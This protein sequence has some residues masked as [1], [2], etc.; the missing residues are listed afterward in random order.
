MPSFGTPGGRRGK[1]FKIFERKLGQGSNKTDF[2]EESHPQGELPGLV[3]VPTNFN[4][5]L[6]KVHSR[7]AYQDSQPIGEGSTDSSQAGG[8]TQENPDPGL[9]GG[10]NS[11]IDRPMGEEETW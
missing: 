10:G 7:L 8:Q 11:L 4:P 3:F 5:I 1:Y 6:P 9:A 2:F